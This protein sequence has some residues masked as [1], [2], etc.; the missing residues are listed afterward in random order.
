MRYTTCDTFHD[1]AFS[2]VNQIAQKPPHTVEHTSRISEKP[3]EYQSASC[4]LGEAFHKYKNLLMCLYLV[5]VTCYL[6][7][8][9]TCLMHI[10]ENTAMSL[11]DAPLS[12]LFSSFSP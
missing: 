3:V 5:P 9:R 11:Y 1:T 6:F 8:Y 10:Q 7:S 4:T 2:L 12:L